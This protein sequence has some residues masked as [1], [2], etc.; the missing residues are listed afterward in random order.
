MFRFRWRR[1]GGIQ[2]TFKASTLPAPVPL[3]YIKPRLRLQTEPFLV[4]SNLRRAQTIFAAIPHSISELGGITLYIYFC[5]VFWPTSTEGRNVWRKSEIF[6]NRHCQ[7]FLTFPD[8]EARLMFCKNILHFEM[9]YFSEPFQRN[10]KE[11]LSTGTNH[12][13]KL[14]C[15]RYSAAVHILRS[16]CFGCVQTLTL[17]NVA[18]D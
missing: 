14:L 18:S 6:T 9:Y 5:T 3:P 7:Y 1:R 2:H 4:W 13:W 15:H 16:K 8:W 17:L 12:E 10:I 11:L